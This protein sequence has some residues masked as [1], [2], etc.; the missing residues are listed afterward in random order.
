MP[1]SQPCSRSAGPDSRAAGT[2]PCGFGANGSSQRFLRF[3]SKDL[4]HRVIQ[5]TA[6]PF[7]EVFLGIV[8]LTVFCQQAAV[9]LFP[10]QHIDHAEGGQTG[11]HAGDAEQLAADDDGEQHPHTG[12]TDAAAHDP[13]GEKVAVDLLDADDEHHK[14]P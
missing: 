1:V 6:V 14:R 12:Y 9:C 8:D 4:D 3:L 2:R 13:G 11:H 5:H 10:D 7:A